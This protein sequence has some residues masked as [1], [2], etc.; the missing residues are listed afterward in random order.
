M[1]DDLIS[2][3]SLFN[4]MLAGRLHLDEPNFVKLM[5]EIK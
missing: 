3:K 5:E 2:R 1:K 4:N